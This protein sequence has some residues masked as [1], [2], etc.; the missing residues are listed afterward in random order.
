MLWSCQY[1]RYEAGRAT[2]GLF[3]NELY[4]ICDLDNVVIREKDACLVFEGECSQAADNRILSN[5]SALHECFGKQS[6]FANCSQD[7]LIVMNP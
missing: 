5:H 2:D 4:G 7:S 6:V 3:R 1:W